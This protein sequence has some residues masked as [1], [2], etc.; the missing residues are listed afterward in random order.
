MYIVDLRSVYPILRDSLSDIDAPTRFRE[1]VPLIYA[2]QTRLQKNWS[3]FTNAAGEVFLHT[4]LIPQTIYK[5]STGDAAP[6]FSSSAAD[7]ARLELVVKSTV[8][9][10]CITM[11]VN[12]DDN[13]DTNVEIHQSTPFLEVVLCTSDAVRSGAC[14]PKKPENRLYMSLFH[15]LHNQSRRFYE[16]RIVTLSSTEPFEYVSV[17]KPLM[18]STTLLLPDSYPSANICLV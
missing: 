3:P 8:D 18:Y 15:V 13:P 5:L 17:S 1:S 2:N 11:A 14:D 7:L 9:R 4:D 16:P 12:P 6:T 10:N